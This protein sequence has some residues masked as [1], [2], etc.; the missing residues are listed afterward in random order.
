MS[1]YHSV[2]VQEVDSSRKRREAREDQITASLLKEHA[3]TERIN[4]L[5]AQKELSERI[6]RDKELAKQLQQSKF[7][8]A[9]D[10]YDIIKQQLEEAKQ[11]HKIQSIASRHELSRL[12]REEKVNARKYIRVMKDRLKVDA[13]DFYFRDADASNLKKRV[14]SA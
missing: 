4:N 8:Y 9:K 13:A 7:N 10:R 5:D 1:N 11:T 3:C 2:S 12:R 14:H 6:K